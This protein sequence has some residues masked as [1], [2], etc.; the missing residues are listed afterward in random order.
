MQRDEATTVEVTGFSWRRRDHTRGS[1]L[2]S[3]LVLALP[4]ICTGL[5]GSAAY[6]LIDLKFVSLL[7][8]APLAAVVVTNQSLRQAAFLLVLGT[9]LGAQAIIA[10]SVGERKSDDAAHVAGQVLLLGS[11]FCVVFALVGGLFPRELLGLVASAGLCWR[12]ASP[13]FA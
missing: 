13:T 11:L 2:V 4:S 1:L 12:L 10:R 5:A 7:G 3:L 8:A 9:S 6:Q